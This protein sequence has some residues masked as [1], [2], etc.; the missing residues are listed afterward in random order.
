MT[1]HKYPTVKLEAHHCRRV[2]LFNLQDKVEQK[3]PELLDYDIIEEVDSPTP[4]VKPAVIIPK[5]DGDIWLCID[6][7][8]H[9]PIPIVDGL[10]HNMNGLKVF[11]KL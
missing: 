2:T 6:V 7:H 4:W 3:V 8:G 10:S 5:M 9:Y 11:S 1:L